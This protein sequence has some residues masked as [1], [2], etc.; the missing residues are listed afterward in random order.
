MIIIGFDTFVSDIGG[1]KKMS[2][3]SVAPGTG[4]DLEYETD[5]KCKYLFTLSF[6]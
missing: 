4:I 3:A 5:G 2:G 6:C 1:Q